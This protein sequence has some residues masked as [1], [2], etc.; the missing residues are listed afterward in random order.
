MPKNLPESTR[1]AYARQLADEAKTL[2]PGAERL[3]DVV[4]ELR[5]DDLYRLLGFDT[6]ERFCTDYLGISKWTANRLMAGPKPKS[7]TA[8]QDVAAVHPAPIVESDALNSATKKSEGAGTGAA[9]V[10][11]T[12]GSRAPV[13]APPPSDPPSGGARDTALPPA[14]KEGPPPSLPAPPDPSEVPGSPDPAHQRPLNPPEFTDLDGLRWLKS[15]NV[16]EVRA[17]GD[18]WGPAIRAEVVR[19]VSAFGL[20]AKPTPEPK[21]GPY[22][23]V[24]YVDRPLTGPSRVIPTAARGKRHADDCRCLSC[25]PPKAVAK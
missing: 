24:A 20:S 25:V 4:V 3:H 16:R 5:Q 9:H 12:A 1:L 21:I 15:K 14:P 18:P 17:I 8:G 23:A 7:I 19:W 10:P 22:Q 6:W 11:N 2:V 13:V